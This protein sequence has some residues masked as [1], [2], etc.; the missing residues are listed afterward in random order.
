MGIK[1]K[2][3][4]KITHYLIFLIFT[5]NIASQELT[6]ML[7]DNEIS[8][9]DF[10]IE[11]NIHPDDF[12]IINP[13]FTNDRFNY[14]ISDLD[15][16]ILVDDE[17]NM[18]NNIDFS[19]NEIEFISHKIRKNESLFDISRIYG[20]SEES[21]LLFNS[22]VEIKKNNLLRIPKNLNLEGR[23]NSI[24]KKYII[25]IDERIWDI[26]FKYNININFLKKINPEIN[27]YLSAGQKIAVP[28]ISKDKLNLYFDDNV[29][30]FKI[31][32]DISISELENNFQINDSSIFILNLDLKSQELKYGDIIFAPKNIKSNSYIIKVEDNKF[33]LTNDINNFDEKK[34]ALILPFR[35]NNFNSE[36]SEI[37]KSIIKNDKL[38]NISLDFLFGVEMALDSFSNL[39]VNLKMD[40]FDSHNDINQI[41]DIVSNNKFESYDFVIGPVSEKLFDYF[42]KLTEDIKIPVI[43]P[44]SKK[45]NKN[46]RIIN[47]IPDDSIFYNRII[48][49]VKNDNSPSSKF[50]ISDLNSVDISNSIKKSFPSAIQIYSK[51]DKNGDD[52]K[53][54]SYED[55]KFKI[56]EGKN[57]IFLESKEQSFI[58]NVSS[59]L[60]SLISDKREIIL[61]TTDKNSSFEGI[62]ISNIHFSNLKFHYPSTNRSYSDFDDS[63]FV[64]KF[65]SKYNYFPNKYS[66]RGFDLVYDLLLRISNGEIN[67]K[68]ILGVENL[69]FENKFKYIRSDSGSFDNIGM[70][71]MKYED[72]NI[73]EVVQDY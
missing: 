8:V 13:R 35:T 14:I 50:I 9:K 19:K 48:S 52:S 67:N 15:K 34:I 6:V 22:K 20:I 69:N 66:F 40:V 61:V 11:N 73:K 7:I 30:K 17:I 49:F 60:N 3:M 21:V 45:L 56:K 5:L 65:I 42:V 58:S 44:L 10:I 4:S 70:F 51:L 68:N 43:R 24:F 46:N 36:N 32:K 47:T 41:D 1:F 55:L 54:I 28:N 29:K 25:K 62:N 59:L 12:F 72:M 53:S 37:Y 57:Y 71:L 18:I 27:N 39:G 26:A 64:Q 63:H 2:I 33:S 23:S 38:L 31:L 16:I